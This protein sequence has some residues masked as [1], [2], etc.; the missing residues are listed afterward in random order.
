MRTV[1]LSIRAV[2]G[3]V[4]DLEEHFAPNWDDLYPDEQTDF[5]LDWTNAMAHLRAVERAREAGELSEQEEADYAPVR[6]RLVELLPTVERLGL[7]GPGV[8]LD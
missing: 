6:T 4:G 1:D 7:T 2:S 5:D 3:E 8:P